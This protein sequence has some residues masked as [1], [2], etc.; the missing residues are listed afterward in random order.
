MKILP[1][2]LDQVILAKLSELTILQICLIFI[3]LTCLVSWFVFI[4]RVRKLLYPP[5]GGGP[6]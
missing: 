1:G 6:M 4:W 5:K 3:V 2:N